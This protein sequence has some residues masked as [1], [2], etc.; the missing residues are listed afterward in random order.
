MQL[1]TVLLGNK[2]ELV[3]AILPTDQLLDLEKVQKHTG[4]DLSIINDMDSQLLRDKNRLDSFDQYPHLIN[5]QTLL[6]QGLGGDSL[7]FSGVPQSA[8]CTPILTADFEQALGQNN[9][10]LLLLDI[11]TDMKLEKPSES[12]TPFDGLQNYKEQCI[13]E[14]VLRFSQLKLGDNLEETLEIP[15][16]PQTAQRIIKLRSNPDA[17]VSELAEAVETDPAL[18]AQIVSWACSPYYAIPGK[19][20]SVHDAIV[21]VLGFDLV[22]NIALGLSLGKTLQ[23]PKDRVAGMTSYWMQSIYCATLMESLVKQVPPQMKPLKGLSYLSGLLHNFGYLVIA[24]VFPLQFS[25]MCRLLEANPHISHQAIEQHLL[26]LTREQIGSWLMETWRMPAE[27]PTAIA[28]QHDASYSESS[29]IYPNLLFIALRQLKKNGIGDAPPEEIPA[30]LYSLHG[31]EE[32]RVNDS[33]ERLIEASDD[34]EQLAA[35]FSS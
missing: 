22:S 32:Q 11:A 24:H 31:L 27:V 8:D 34:L 23:L 2:E 12:I 20:R 18:A 17:D 13:R 14:S 7:T 6:H 5:T 26:Q 16:L 29:K 1:R 21:R 25:Q 9:H 19:V 28:Y 4:R 33:V 15:P 10:Q 3:Q 35:N 30:E